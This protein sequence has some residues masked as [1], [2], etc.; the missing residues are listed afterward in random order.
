MQATPI[1]PGMNRK[2]AERRRN[3]VPSAPNIDPRTGVPSEPNIYPRNVKQ[4]IVWLEAEVDYMMNDALPSL[5]DA[6]KALSALVN[7]LQTTRNPLWFPPQ[8]PLYSSVPYVPMP[9]PMQPNNWP[10]SENC[11]PVGPDAGV[12]GTEPVAH[13]MRYENSN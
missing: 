9:N 10:K 12:M 11:L 2:R 6:V 13:Q 7:Y 3:G 1:N 4:R 5:M 8:Q